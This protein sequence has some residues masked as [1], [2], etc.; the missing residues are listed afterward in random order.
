MVW[1]GVL[2]AVVVVLEVLRR[3]RRFAL[4]ALLVSIGFAGTLA[5]MNVDRTIV[6]QNV[7]RATTGQGLDVPY[8]ASLSSDSVPFLV[9]EFQSS[10]LPGLTREAVGAVLICHSY[11]APTRSDTNWR[12][13]TLTD[14]QANQ[15][16]ET[17]QAELNSYSVNDDE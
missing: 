12:A 15:A 4:A 9:E 11:R 2:L 3:E 5:L 8:L 17:V 14:W 7:A 1:L 10:A 13:F 16:I 6:R